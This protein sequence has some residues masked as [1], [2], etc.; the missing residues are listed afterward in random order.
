VEWIVNADFRRDVTAMK[1]KPLFIGLV[2]GVVIGFFLAYLYFISTSASTMGQKVF[3]FV[4][5]S[6]GII[7]ALTYFCRTYVEHRLGVES[8]RVKIR[9][10]KTYSLRADAI[11]EVHGRFLD[12]YEAVNEFQ[13]TGSRD[14]NSEQWHTAIHRINAAR[15]SL[16]DLLSR[17]QLYLPKTT[18]AKIRD[19]FGRVYGS[20]LRYTLLTEENSEAERVE[21]KSVELKKWLEEK[22]Q[23]SAY[24]SLLEDDFRDALGFLD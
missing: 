4:G 11:S 1:T 21:L 15:D 2:I 24:L 22:D 17:K 7:A 12:L 6:A 19:L 14:V 13:F 18:T 20:H 5:G 3:A 16:I 9:F 10:T 23:M 8:E